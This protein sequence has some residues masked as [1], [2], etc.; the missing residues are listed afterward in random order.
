[1]A[2]LVL[3]LTYPSGAK[4]TSLAEKVKNAYTHKRYM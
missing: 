2:R 4:K 3:I 1:M